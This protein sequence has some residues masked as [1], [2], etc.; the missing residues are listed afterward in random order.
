MEY[1]WWI[2]GW[3]VVGKWLVNCWLVNGWW[4]IG[5]WVNGW[6]MVV[7]VK[8][9]N[10]NFMSINRFL[11]INWKG[12]KSSPSSWAQYWLSTMNHKHFLYSLNKPGYEYWIGTLIILAN[13]DNLTNFLSATSETISNLNKTLCWLH[14]REII[15]LSI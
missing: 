11:K 8:L 3:W 1:H 14:I 2:A 9:I 7:F 5:K 4:M 15:M 12:G 10:W 6:S 13:L